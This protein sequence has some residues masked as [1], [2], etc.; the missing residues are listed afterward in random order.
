[1]KNTLI[2]LFLCIASIGFAQT[3][4]T[5][6]KGNYFITS[7]LYKNKLNIVISKWQEIAPVALKDNLW[8]IPNTVY[9]EN[10]EL[11]ESRIDLY[12]CVIR[13]V[14]KSELIGVEF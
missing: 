1:M 12:K 14:K 10:K 6:L 5:Y 8:M 13:K 3:D 9:L 2:I 7:S 11:V 4:M